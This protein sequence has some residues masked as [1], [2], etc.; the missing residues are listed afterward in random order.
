MNLFLSHKNIPSHCRPSPV[1]P[2]SQVQSNDPRLFVQV[3]LSEQSWVI[4]SHS[5]SSKNYCKKLK[6]IEK[7]TEK[8]TGLLSSL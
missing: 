1:K 7:T 5:L 2:A 4:S 6:G 8:S 3:A